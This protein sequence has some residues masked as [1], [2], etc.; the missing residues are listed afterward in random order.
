MHSVQDYGCHG[1]KWRLYQSPEHG[2]G[3]NI[4]SAS[5]SRFPSV[6]KQPVAEPSQGG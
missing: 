1:L 2:R 6:P 5:P 4:S 3:P